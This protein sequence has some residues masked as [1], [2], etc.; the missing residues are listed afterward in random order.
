MRDLMTETAA[1][2]A[3]HIGAYKQGTLTLFLNKLVFSGV[4]LIHW[5]DYYEHVY[6]NL[7]QLLCTVQIR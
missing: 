1:F 3:A 7:L 4:A 2:F 5:A 6:F